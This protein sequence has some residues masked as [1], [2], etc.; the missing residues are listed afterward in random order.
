MELDGRTFNVGG[1]DGQPVHN[2][3]DPKWLEAMTPDTNG[4]EFS[5]VR[6][7]RT[8]PR[9]AWQKNVKWL[10]QQL[11]WPPPGVGVTLSF[12]A[13]GACPGI[14]LQ[15]HYELYDGLP[16]MAKWLTLS[17]ASSARVTL[18]SL[19]VEQLAL[20]EP[21]SIVDGTAG[22]FSRRIP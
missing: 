22:Q 4:F 11:P 3:L 17:N 20:V 1:L 10:S 9:F 7:G 16:L 2:Y 8:E 5:S 21:E 18:N 15:V 19:I 13:P 12:V 14:E 6:V